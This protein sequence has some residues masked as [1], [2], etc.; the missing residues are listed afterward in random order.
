MWQHAQIVAIPSEPPLNHLSLCS[1]QLVLDFLDT[2]NQD[3]IR[4][5]SS[6]QLTNHPS[7]PR[8]QPK[9]LSSQIKPSTPSAPTPIEPSESSTK[10]ICDG[11]VCQ[12]IILTK[13]INEKNEKESDEK[14]GDVEPMLREEG[15]RFVLFPIRYDELYHLY[16]KA[17]SAFW[18]V[19]EVDLAEDMKD[20]DNMTDGE[21]HFIKHVLA[22]FAAADGIVIENLAMRFMNDVKLPEAKNFYAVQM[23]QE[24]I[25]SEMYSILVDTFVRD[26]AEKEKLFAAIVTM[27]AVKAKADW[28]LKWMASERTFAERL[29]AFAAVEM[30]MFSGSFCALYWLKKRGKMPGLTFS[31]EKDCR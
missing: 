13:T 24:A 6:N 17:L 2:F 20:W 26:A 18:I 21:R 16:K 4:Q 29:V 23:Q 9:D 1:F 12:R 3:T 25:H 8:F 10:I 31:N 7:M 22:F 27:P 28:A 14:K 30:I 5:V 11:D 15:N 19:E